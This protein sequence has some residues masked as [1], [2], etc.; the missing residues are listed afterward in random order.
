MAD[1][2]KVASVGALR[3]FRAALLRFA[4]AGLGA[5]MEADSDISRTIMWLRHERTAYWKQQIRARSDRVSALKAELHRKRITSQLENPSLV[6][7]RR[8]VTRATEAVAEAEAKLEATQRWARTLEHERDLYR[9]EVQ[10]FSAIVDSDLPL[11]AARLGRLI[12]RLDRYAEVSARRGAAGDGRDDRGGDGREAGES[13]IGES[14]WA[15]LFD[16]GGGDGGGPGV[17]DAKGGKV[18]GL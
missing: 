3:D 9:G 15:W 2:A 17:D 8:A 10:M 5:L 11:G 16:D 7:E 6:L 14:D 4:E 1:S 13:G 18:G 12:D